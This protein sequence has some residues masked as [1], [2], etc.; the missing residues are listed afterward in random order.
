LLEDEAL[1]MGGI[2]INIPSIPLYNPNQSQVS[3]SSYLKI[4][5]LNH[6]WFNGEGQEMLKKMKI[7]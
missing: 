4:D 5:P 3:S 2:N 6:S 7:N 1:G